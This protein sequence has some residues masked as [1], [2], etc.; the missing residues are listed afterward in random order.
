MR[1]KPDTGLFGIATVALALLFI[2]IHNTWDAV[3]YHVFVARGRRSPKQ[4][5]E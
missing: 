5:P 2:G 1:S 4:P 3:I